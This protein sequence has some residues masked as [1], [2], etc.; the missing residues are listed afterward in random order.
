MNSLREDLVN[1]YLCLLYFMYNATNIT[2]NNCR[3]S[4]KFDAKVYY[5]SFLAYSKRGKPTVL[6][7]N[8]KCLFERPLVSDN[9]LQ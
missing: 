7:T 5:V 6:L 4:D 1:S 3:V 9:G 8:V 2:N